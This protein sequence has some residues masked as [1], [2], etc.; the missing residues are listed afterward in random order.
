[1]SAAHAAAVSSSGPMSAVRAHEI[2]GAGR[3]KTDLWLILA[4]QK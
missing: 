4:A 2:N 3:A 1:L